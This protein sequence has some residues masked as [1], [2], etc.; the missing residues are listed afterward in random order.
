MRTYF[1][2][3]LPVVKRGFGYGFGAFLCLALNEYYLASL[4]FLSDS[5]PLAMVLSFLKVYL[6]QVGIYEGWR[7]MRP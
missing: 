5:A 7:N 3:A 4:T 1:S 6:K 2:I